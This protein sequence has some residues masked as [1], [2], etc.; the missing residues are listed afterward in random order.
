MP[1][2]T[3]STFNIYS[4]RNVT[5][6]VFAQRLRA[7]AGDYLVE[8]VI[9]GTQLEG[10]WDLDLRWNGRARVL[11]PGTERVTIFDAVQKD[12]GLILMLKDSAR[13]VL[14][15][16]RVNE[17]PTPDAPGTAQKLPQ[18][19]VAFEVADLKPSR[20][21]ES[22]VMQQT[23]GGGLEVRAV[24]LGNL[25]TAAWDID[26]GHPERIS[27][28]PTGR[29]LPNSTSMRKRRRARTRCRFLARAISTTRAS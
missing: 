11:P 17:Q 5:M 21:G 1:Q 3:G 16:D 20:P 26:Q 23:R 8:P 4:C 19:E 13:S 14:V 24:P 12:L 15:V 28:F 25:I 6:P 27:G 29:S 9:D 22:A 18:E 2:P 7:L 10:S